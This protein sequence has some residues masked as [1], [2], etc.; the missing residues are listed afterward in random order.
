M[1]IKK[2]RK[3]IKAQNAHNEAS[4][5]KNVIKDQIPQNKNDQRHNFAN[6]HPERQSF[7]M[8]PEETIFQRLVQREVPERRKRV[9]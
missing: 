3:G 4:Q 6:K 8:I 1:E 9:H 7:A 5:Q 2:S